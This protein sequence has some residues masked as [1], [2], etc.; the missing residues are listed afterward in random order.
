MGAGDGVNVEIGVGFEAGIGVGVGVGVFS[1]PTV[2]RRT[3]STHLLP[4]PVSDHIRE[5]KHFTFSQSSFFNKA[6]TP[7][8]PR[9]TDALSVHGLER[10]VDLTLV[11]QRD[12]GEALAARLVTVHDDALDGESRIGKDPVHRNVV[13]G[14]GD[15]ADVQLQ[16]IRVNATHAGLKGWGWTGGGGKVFCEV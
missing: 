2:Y 14:A 4:S 1:T 16:V 11:F 7:I 5:Q 12:K 10:V 15:A 9:L 3:S 13:H 6:L 8:E